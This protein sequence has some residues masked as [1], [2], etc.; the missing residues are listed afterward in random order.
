MLLLQRLHDLARLDVHSLIEGE[1]IGQDYPS[2]IKLNQEKSPP[3]ANLNAPKYESVIL[4]H[5]ENIEPYKNEELW[6]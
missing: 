2:N 5:L 4:E 6:R 3:D 1:R